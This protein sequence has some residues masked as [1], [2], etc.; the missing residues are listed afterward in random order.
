[1]N[2][3][4]IRTV[5]V[6]ANTATNLNH[7]SGYQPVAMMS[8]TPE[9]VVSNPSAAAGVSL[10]ASTVSSLLQDD[11]DLPAPTVKAEPGVSQ[12][13]QSNRRTRAT[14]KLTKDDDELIKDTVY[15]ESLSKKERDAGCELFF[16]HMRPDGWKRVNGDLGWTY[17]YRA[18]G[19][20]KKTQVPDVNMFPGYAAIYDQWKKDGCA[21]DRILARPM[22]HA[23]A[24]NLDALR[25]QTQ[26]ATNDAPAQHHVHWSKSALQSPP[27]MSSSRCAIDRIA[28]QMEHAHAINLDA[29]RQQTQAA[30]NDDPVQHHV[31]W[32][33]RALQ[34]PPE[35]SSSRCAIDRIARQMEHAHAI[36]LDVLPQ[37]TQAATNDAPVQHHV[38]WSKSALQSPPEMSSSRCAIDRILARPMEY[39]HAINLDVLP[40]QTKAA[41][42]DAPVQHHVHWSK[43][44]LKSPLTDEVRALKKTLDEKCNQK[45]PGNKKTSVKVNGTSNKRNER[46]GTSGASTGKRKR[47][48]INDQQDSTAAASTK[49]AHHETN[50]NDDTAMQQ[51]AVAAT[52]SHIQ[53]LELF[54]SS[55]QV[56]SNLGVEKLSIEQRLQR[57]EM[58]YFGKTKE[59]LLAF[60]RFN[61]LEKHF[62]VNKVASA[63]TERI[64]VL[65]K[66][67]C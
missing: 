3:I 47:E 44:A 61:N 54:S 42:N 35:M 6:R 8:M 64:S 59:D 10:T 41:T 39:A 57:V 22:E 31:H 25:Q 1:M 51:W 18:R 14:I 56:L 20:T 26:A 19:V 45:R 49:R 17:A 33:K 2:G 40:Q 32:S 38:H 9:T 16:T 48:S 52:P 12:Y 66:I 11:I 29:L 63:F 15:K 50:T 23:H 4:F 27:E 67:L 46:N 36:N 60:Q 21:I 65:E 62:G 53:R 30:T 24:I 7:P 13:G 34:S 58:R 28:R 43:S 37:Q 5:E 55:C